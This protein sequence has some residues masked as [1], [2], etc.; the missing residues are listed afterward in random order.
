LKQLSDFWERK[1]K[2]TALMIIVLV[3]LTA[4]G[5]KSPEATQDLLATIVQQTLSSVPTNTEI[6]T[7]TEETPVLVTLTPE[8]SITPSITMSPTIINDEIR[9]TLGSPVWAD[10][11]NDCSS[12]GLCTPYED[13]NSKV[14]VSS[15]AMIMTSKITGGYQ[16]WRLTY[17][18]PQNMYL[19]GTFTVQTCSGGDMYGLVFRAK[20]YTSGVGYYLGVTCDGRY[21]LDKWD[22]SGKSNVFALTQSDAIFTGSN[23]TNR[24]GVLANGDSFRIYINGKF[25][26]EIIDPGIKEE[27]YIG[28]FIAGLNTP[29]FTIELTDIAYWN[30]P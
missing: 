13:E 9:N 22:T 3:I 12:F 5:V 4:C 17:P 26:Q 28:A 8:P 14:S 16:T 24:V 10:Q 30:L 1:M 27:G 2:K 11:L 20:D 23:Q 7:R 29:G 6:P 18:R 21:G 19:E 15:G 25:L